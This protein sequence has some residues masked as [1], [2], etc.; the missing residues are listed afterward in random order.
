MTCRVSVCACGRVARPHLL[1]AP[2][3]AQDVPKDWELRNSDL[4]GVFLRVGD[5]E[6]TNELAT[7][8]PHGEM[9][10][11]ACE[12]GFRGGA[13]AARHTLLRRRQDAGRAVSTLEI[14]TSSSLRATVRRSLMYAGSFGGVGTTSAPS[15]A[16]AAITLQRPGRGHERSR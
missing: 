1:L 7:L 4:P 11:M 8:T 3:G 12:R 14:A 5:S 2:R 13:T 9:G 15:A 16:A 10:E 6:E